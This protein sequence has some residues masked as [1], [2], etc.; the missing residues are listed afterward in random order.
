MGIFDATDYLTV[1]SASRKCGRET[2]PLSEKN[3]NR[4]DQF[5]ASFPLISVEYYYMWYFN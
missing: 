5:P 3:P 2:A 1:L 4:V